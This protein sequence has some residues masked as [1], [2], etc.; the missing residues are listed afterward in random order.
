MDLEYDVQSLIL[1]QKRK[2]KEE[3]RER[4]RREK[5]RERQRQR[6][7][8]RDRQIQIQRETDRKRQRE[9]LDYKELKQME[10]LRQFPATDPNFHTL[11]SLA[12]RIQKILRLF[13]WKRIS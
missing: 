6:G 10:T 4:Q 1:I 11:Q 9:S 8:E 12:R 2:E 3:R 7:R 13:F 5:D